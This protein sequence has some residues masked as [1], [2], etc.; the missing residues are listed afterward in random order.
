MDID[1]LRDQTVAYLA[2]RWPELQEGAPWLVDECF[3]SAR[4]SFRNEFICQLGPQAWARITLIYFKHFLD[5]GCD[6]SVGEM[7]A[8]VIRDSINL[9]R[10]DMLILDLAQQ[11][12]EQAGHQKK[13]SLKVVKKDET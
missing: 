4:K 3:A 7:F 9:N 10:L 2:L 12:Q 11:K 1:S 8:A 6:V 5:T 13:T